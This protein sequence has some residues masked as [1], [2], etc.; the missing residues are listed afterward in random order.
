MSMET[1]Q[2]Q[3]WNRMEGESLTWYRRFER[4]RLMEPTRSIAAV[5]AQEYSKRPEKTRKSL[6]ADGTWYA[7]AKQWDWEAR[8]AAW[9]AY[10][11]EQIEKQIAAERK[12]VLK[13]RFALMHKRVELLDQKIAQLAQIT[14]TEE[15]IW[16]ADVKS[17]GT[18]PTAERVDLV[19]FNDAA[20][21]E[22]R[23]YMKDIA[24]EM[25][26]RVKTTKQEVS[27][28]LDVVGAKEQL[29]AKL[30]QM[31][32]GNDVKHDEQETE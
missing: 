20:F 17:V 14:D 9:D 18:G 27:G 11:D 30:S 16:M 29:L 3:V 31:S 24:D 28:S 1:E 19:Q 25:G 2:Q 21:R 26:E 12:K 15:R 7:I 4:F 32:R 22:L 10:Q 23:E 13:S 8:A 6:V 5:F